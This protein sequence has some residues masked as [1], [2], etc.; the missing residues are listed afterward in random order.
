MKRYPAW[1][2]RLLVESDAGQGDSPAGV[3]V[4]RARFS[5]A[6]QAQARVEGNGDSG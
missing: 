6:R 3:T 4:W 1:G 5:A 2:E